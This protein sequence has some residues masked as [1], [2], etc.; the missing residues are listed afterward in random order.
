MK[1][2]ILIILLAVFSIPVFSQDFSDVKLCINPGHG[3]HDSD[4]RYISATGFWE[5]E[6]NLSKGLY[7]RDI[8]QALNCKIVMTRVTNTTADDLPLSQIVAIANSNNVDWMHAIHSNATGGTTVTTNYTLLLYQGNDSKPTFPATYNMASYMKSEIYAAQR[9]TDGRQA[10]DF[11]FYGTGQA[12]LGVFKGLTMPG[13]LSEGEFHDYI[14]GSWRLQNEMYKKHEAW[15][16]ARAFIRNWNK[17]PFTHGIVAG[18]LRDKFTNVTYPCL[19]A[20]QK[21]PINYVKVT[22]QP[23]N[24]VYTG[25]NMNN[26]FYMFDSLAPGTY[27]LTFEAPDYTK[28]TATV[29]VIANRSVFADALLLP[30]T[31]AGPV[32]AVYSPSTSDSV[33]TSS[34]VSVTFSRPMSRTSVQSAFNFTP[35]VD[36]SFVWSNNDQT[37][38]FTPTYAYDKSTKYQLVISAGAQS[39]YGVPMQNDFKLSFVTKYRNR[40][41][42]LSTSP[43][44]WENGISTKFQA[45]AVFDTPLMTTISLNNCVALY[46]DQNNRLTIKNARR[47]TDNGR[48]IILFEPKDALQ[49]NKIYKILFLGANK[50]VDGIPQYDTVTINF[51]TTAEKYQNGTVLDS[52]ESILKW[53]QPSQSSNSTGIDNTVSAISLASSSSA[54][55]DGYY[56]GRMTYEFTKASGGLCE[57]VDNA[58]P[59]IPSGASNFGM[60]VFGDNS[61]NILEFWFIRSDNSIDK[62]VVDTL[63]W[64]GWR[65]IQLPLASIPGSGNR[66]LNS[67]VIRQVA[68]AKD[69]SSIFIDNIQ[70]SITT[71]VK[72]E[73]RI[74]PANFV[75]EQNY[76]NPFNP[77]TTISWQMPKA[78]HV[79]LKVYDVLGRVVADLLNENRNAGTYKFSFDAGKFNLASGVYLY[80]LQAGEFSQIRKMI[81]NK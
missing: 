35:A 38:T 3:G 42:I 68:G 2:F 18:I 76:P 25:D 15:A 10:G 40:L 63:N 22:L 33:L 4:D 55:I 26:G 57:Y 9:T 7:L 65:I 53:Q 14:P 41:K 81:L 66:T 37:V 50:D 12:Y 74:Q 30:D 77:S 44:D 80:K 1:K 72:E 21:K 36:G 6:G 29:T 39:V 11:D 46:D 62:V 54:I 59:V 61:Q 13:T 34:S 79:S 45:Q 64:G 49:S 78:A 5:S 8:M 47:Y 67:V 43:A 69:S 23:G 20:D 73:T 17:T 51:V 75:L 58:K 27:K 28:D 52:M 16:I 31:T 48:G 71:P 24:K 60:W 19:S 70:Y 56:S 32:V